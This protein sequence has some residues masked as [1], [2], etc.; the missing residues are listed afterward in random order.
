MEVL[1]EQRVK[2]EGP[3]P[4]SETS[5]AVSIELSDVQM[6]LEFEED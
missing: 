2:H 6:P 4:L 1:I 5:A 3:L